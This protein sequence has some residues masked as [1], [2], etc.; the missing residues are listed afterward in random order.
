MTSKTALKIATAVNLV[1]ALAGTARAQTDAS[2]R[3]S[4]A[5][6]QPPGDGPQDRALRAAHLEVPEDRPV[7]QR[8]R[9]TSPARRWA[10]NGYVSVQVNVDEF[11][12]NIVGDAANEPSIAVDPHAPRRMAI[13]WRQFDTIASNFRQA[14]WGYTADGGQSWTFPGVVNPGVFRSD[15]V[16]C[17]N[18]AGTFF[19]NSL[20]ASDDEY[21]CNVYKSA[22]GGASW[23]SGVYA[24]G[25]DKQWMA[26]DLTDGI[27]QDNL[28]AYWTRW[29]T[30]PN[31]NG[32][33]TRSYD[34]GQTFLPT[35]DVPGN[36]Q[37]GTLAVGP[38]GELY[39]AGMG[40]TVTKSGTMQDQTLPAAFDFSVTV[41]LDGSIGFSGGPNPGG[42]LGQAWIAVDHS[43]GPT[44]G[45]VYLLCSVQRS[46]TVD[47]LDVMFAR[48]TDGGLT[49]SDPVRVNDD[50]EDNGAYQWFGTM[51]VA[52]NG[53]ID[54]VW[55]DT[56]ND[57]GGYYSEL[58]YAY[59]TDAGQTWSPNEALTPSFHPYLGWP[60]QNKLG[61]YNDM[62][63]D[64][65]GVS[66]AYAATFN[67][68]QDVYYLRIGEPFCK[69]AGTVALDLAKY[70]CE[71]TVTITVADCGLGNDND[72]IESVIVDIDSDSETG[73]EQATLVEIAA[74]TGWFEGS[75]DLSEVNSSGVLWVAEGD[76]VTVTYLDADDGAGGSNIAVTADAP[77]DCT[78]PLI[79]NVQ[80]IDVAP[81]DAV[82][83]F[84]TNESAAGV[85][86]YGSA[87]EAL[88]K[89]ARRGGF[90]TNH[91]VPLLGLDE[92]STYFYAVDAG[93]EAGNSASD[94]QGGNCYTFTTP[95]RVDYLTEQFI[96]ANDL[97]YLSLWFIPDDSSAH[98]AA[99][100]R[101]IAELPTDPA[102]GTTLP[103][104]DN[105]TSAVFLTGGKRV[106]VFGASYGT[107]YVGANGYVTF[108]SGD[109]E[110]EE[111][112]ENHFHLPRISA[113][114]DDLNPRLGDGNVSWKQL[115]DRVAVTWEDVLEANTYN[116]WNTFQI[117]MYFN[118]TIV[119]SY[120]EIMARDGLT[121][122]SAG[123]GVPIWFYETDVS[124][125]GSC[126][127][128]C[129][130]N[131]VPDFADLVEGVSADC[132]GDGRPDE[133][134][135]L[136]ECELA[137]VTAPD[138]EPT[139]GSS[140]AIKGDVAVV[141]AYGDDCA[142]GGWCGSA[143]VYRFDGAAWN[144][145]ARLTASDAAANDVFGCAVAVSGDLAVVGA[146]GVDCPAGESC[147]G[148]YVYRFDGTGWEEEEKLMAAD[149]ALRDYFGMSVAVDGDLIVVGANEDD[150]AAGSDCGSAYVYRYDPGPP[151][152]W[153]PEAKLTAPDGAA[154]DWFGMS[155][156]VSN[157][158]V[159]VGAHGDDCSPGV[160][161]C[162]AAYIYR[163]DGGSWIEEDKLTGADGYG[164][165]V[166]IDADAVIVG[167]PWHD[168]AQGSECGEAYIYRYEED[169]WIEQGRTTAPDAQAGDLLGRSVSISGDL[170][171]ASATGVDC[172]AGDLCG[173]VTV[174]YFDGYT[175]NQVLELT[176]SDAAAFR[177]FGVAAAISANLAVVGASGAAY[178]FTVAGED[179]NCNE[180]ADL[181]DVHLATSRDCNGNATP[182]ECEVI[183][184]G[185]FSADGAV[186]L[187]DHVML[188]DCLAG[189]GK[190]PNP[191][192]SQ[193][194]DACLAAFDFDDDG[195]VDLADLG[196][197][198]RVFG[199]QGSLDPPP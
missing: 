127:G 76:T 137:K 181:C 80:A 14:G 65:R 2:T 109:I 52:P 138:A 140:V 49:W 153:A 9:V 159:V 107:F 186:T 32:H 40:F 170:A 126:A 90:H 184:D 37:W 141:G 189:P 82:V 162:G 131:G 194:V 157:N 104:S 97:D 36:P 19:Y 34:G 108:G 50:S 196:D 161:D 16:L 27:G 151:A 133:C 35:I 31:C 145:E 165:P 124:A 74:G 154:R 12:D 55:N 150:C 163:Y 15:P 105:G 13:G 57:P 1:L 8:A 84:E 45:N 3:S 85:A 168:C 86:R 38:D 17:A 89:T 111:S 180:A 171:V 70:A 149:A 169:T 98:Y 101:P 29:Y 102:G 51:S 48:S 182:D 135:V 20:T 183:N 42:L 30:C 119:I 21:W 123:G 175:W 11:G 5:Q 99:C 128:D 58:Y 166:C 96:I 179:C 132:N 146:Y 46:S 139:F 6:V 197:F 62:V 134:G 118:G 7:Q 26:A 143:Y 198:H 24:Y 129:N 115:P 78:P 174:S 164:Y 95:D 64:S 106:S 94:D 68:E 155:V 25:G 100:A 199:F 4:P 160:G 33:F 172:T 122:L 73:V 93:D 88:T 130:E 121:G 18:T 72:V 167:A 187:D 28:Y 116:S 59:S 79:S 173:S 22:D 142:A 144:A 43:D 120:L 192:E 110:Y 156:S 117:E 185:D 113:L 67:G 10:R 60:Q 39:I 81:R 195:D 44:R 41:D 53:R 69:E 147:G 91:A 103:L 112:L 190:T 178:L 87:C 158:A 114:F 152:H 125:M 77:V 71:S 54:A 47:P 92:S 61:D 191:A 193:C 176:A 83:T 23:D 148:A 66:L 177:E 75:I 56:R 188:T 63:S 136:A